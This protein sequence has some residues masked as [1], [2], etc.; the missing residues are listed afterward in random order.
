MRQEAV[1]KPI[2]KVITS[3]DKKKE[4]VSKKVIRVDN[5]NEFPSLVDPKVIE[6]KNKQQVF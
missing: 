4:V 5:L 1:H 2:G 6:K 3:P